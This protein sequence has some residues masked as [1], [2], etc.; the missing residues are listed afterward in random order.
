[1][2]VFKEVDEALQQ[3]KFSKLWARFKFHAIGTACLVLAG[4]AGAVYWQDAR[5][6]GFIERTQRLEQALLQAG[7]QNTAEALNI[8][9]TLLKDTDAPVVLLH[10]ATIAY[11]GGDEARAR[12][13][14]A[15]IQ[16][17]SPYA[18]LA[19]LL[20]L[21]LQISTAEPAEPAL[22]QQ[23]E[24]FWIGHGPKPYRN[25]ARRLA[26]G[27]LL[28]QGDVQGARDLLQAIADDLEANILARNEARQTLK[29]LELGP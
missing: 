20:S 27:L 16:D 7:E 5:Q 28:E 29:L 23:L 4:V 19:T 6:T 11:R 21:S 14:L 10:G 8:I 24:T 26:S 12:R 13:Y 1:M 15:Q 3:E 18:T 22:L 17:D 25:L 9:E 2:D